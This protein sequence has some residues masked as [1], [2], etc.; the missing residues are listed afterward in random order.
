VNVAEGVV[1]V[2]N[3]VEGWAGF[4]IVSWLE[5]LTGLPVALENDANT[6]ALAEACKGAGRDYRYVCFLTLG[7]GCGGGMVADGYIYHGA[8]PGESEVGLQALNR[9]GAT[10]E[11]SCCGWAVDRKVRD[12]VAEH[13]ESILADLVGEE[14]GAEARFLVSAIDRG[15]AGA[16]AMLEETAEDLAFGLS[17]VTHLLH[18]EIIC[19]GGGLSLM[20]EP[21]R[22]AVAEHLPRFVHPAYQP[23]PHIAITEL[24]EDAIA[25]GALI[26]ARRKAA[27]VESR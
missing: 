6:G 11:S 19:L 3:Q 1:A 18:P 10:V 25:M 5:C 26:L 9:D 14:E 15:D 8:P 2:S 27:N 20:G 24:G 21:L 16:H 12:Y 22:A 7:S 4:P 23:S 17:H 13:P